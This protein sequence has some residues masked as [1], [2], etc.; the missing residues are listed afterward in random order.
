MINPTSTRYLTGTDM[1][2]YPWV[3]VQIQFF[4]RSLF[5]GG[6][7]IALPDPLPSLSTKSQ[8]QFGTVVLAVL[9]RANGPN[10]SLVIWTG[11]VFLITWTYHLGE[12]V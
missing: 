11:T 7:V 4:T 10:T 1:N 12:I 6:R 9:V 5:I 2:F 3:R 8:T